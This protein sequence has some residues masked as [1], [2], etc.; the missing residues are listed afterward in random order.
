MGRSTPHTPWNVNLD[1]KDSVNVREWIRE[2]QENELL[3][4]TEVD[5]DDDMLGDLDGPG[6]GE[7]LRL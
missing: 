7:D 6:P 2:N 1:L 5:L 4:V 3:R